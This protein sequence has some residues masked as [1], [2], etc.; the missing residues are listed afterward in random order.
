MSHM[1]SIFS[2]DILLMRKWQFCIGCRYESSWFLCLDTW[3]F[4]LRRR[5][6]NIQKDPDLSCLSLYWCV[7]PATVSLFLLYSSLL[8]KAVWEKSFH[9]EYISLKILLMWV[10]Q[11]G[12]LM[13][14]ASCC[15]RMLLVNNMKSLRTRFTHTWTH[16]AVKHLL[17]WQTS[18]HTCM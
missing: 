18:T 5:G 9:V 7:S 17:V 12:V 10:L 13:L 2:L 16:C 3:S 6:F 11:S 15:M 8:S 14:H 4:L 1:D